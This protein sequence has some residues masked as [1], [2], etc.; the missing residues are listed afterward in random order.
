MTNAIAA[1]APIRTMLS[2]GSSEPLIIE[3]T[4][5]PDRALITIT[6]RMKA[7]TAISRDSP[8]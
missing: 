7:A 6:L 2:E 4:K 5:V 8:T 1:P 3:D